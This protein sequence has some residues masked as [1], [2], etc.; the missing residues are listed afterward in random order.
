MR[1]RN[2]SISDD[3]HRRLKIR[4]ATLD[5]TF[6]RCIE[7]LLDVYDAMLEDIESERLEDVKAARLE[8]A[9][10]QMAELKARI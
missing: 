5:M 10:R 4:A 1:N 6:G 8:E 9:R 3:V 2:F 7:H